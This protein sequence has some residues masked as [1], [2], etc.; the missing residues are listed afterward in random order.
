M[1]TERVLKV[2]VDSPFKT[3]KLTNHKSITI[4]QW[5]CVGEGDEVFKRNGKNYV[6]CIN[7]EAQFA[8]PYD[9]LDVL[10]IGARKLPVHVKEIT[11]IDE[12]Q[13]YQY[14]QSFHYRGNG[15]FG[16]KSIL[17]VVPDEPL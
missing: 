7:G 10:G 13:A 9:Q 16:R 8:P 4:S 12:F 15:G 6:R 17:V 11:T 3:L 2:T 5:A 1:H 14:L